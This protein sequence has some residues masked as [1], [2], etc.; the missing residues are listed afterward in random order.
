M[1]S[2]FETAENIQFI[3]CVIDH[4]WRQEVSIKFTQKQKKKE[5]K[6]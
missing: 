4:N 5:K 1:I 6:H 2:H 3:W